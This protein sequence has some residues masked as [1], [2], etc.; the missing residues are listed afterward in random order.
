MSYDGMN[1][2]S[3][4][5]YYGP[6]RTQSEWLEAI[7]ATNTIPSSAQTPKR[8][9]LCSTLRRCIRALL[10]IGLIEHRR[11]NRTTAALTR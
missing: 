5:W 7:G 1:D 3:H 6:Y 2:K 4:A 8:P 10:G 9:R 11:P